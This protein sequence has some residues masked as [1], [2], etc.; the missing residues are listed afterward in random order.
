MCMRACAC[1]RVLLLRF[2][3]IVALRRFFFFPLLSLVVLSFHAPSTH[4]LLQLRLSSVVPI[5]K[6]GGGGTAKALMGRRLSLSVLL[7]LFA[8][9]M[10]PAYGAHFGDIKGSSSLSAGATAPR[11]RIEG[12]VGKLPSLS[13]SSLCLCF[14][15]AQQKK[16]RRSGSRCEATATPCGQCGWRKSDVRQSRD[17]G[18]ISGCRA[19]LSEEIDF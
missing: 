12:C 17:E 15:R 11:G 2:S 4:S 3:R 7:S 14:F 5:T 8:S 10:I 16:N 1:V 13:Y 18:V 9:L 6:G 19:S